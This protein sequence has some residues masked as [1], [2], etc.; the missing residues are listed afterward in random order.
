MNKHAKDPQSEKGQRPMGGSRRCARACLAC[1]TALTLILCAGCAFGKR[2]HAAAHVTQGD[3][4]R[5]GDA[6]KDEPTV[7]LEEIEE[8]YES[9]LDE[10]R[11]MNM[12][13]PLELDPYGGWLNAP[14]S[15]KTSN[16]SGYFRVEKL[17]GAWWFVTPDGNPFVSKGVTDVN[18]LG[19]TLAPDAFHDIIVAKYGTEEAWVEAARNRMLDWGFNTIG[20]WSSPS[21][22]KQMPHAYIILDIGGA[23]GPRYPG[24]VVSDYYA[25]AFV[26]YAAAMTEQ[27]AKPHAEDKN[28]IGFFLDNEIVWGA[29]HF[30]TDKSLL[31]LHVEFP[32]DAPGRAEAL[33]FI[34]E[35]AG[36]LEAFNAAWKT[37]ITDW[38]NLTTLSGDTFSPD[39]DAARALTEAFML[40]TFHRYMAVGLEALRA[41][42][43]HHLI[44]GCRFHN[45]PGDVLYEAAAAYFDVIA[46]AFYEPR[47]PVAEIDAI[48]ERVD[49]P[50][51]IEE[52]TFKSHDSGTKNS[53]F[54]IYAPEVRTMEE[55]SLAYD[56]YIETFVRRPYG[57]GYH[58][59][60][61]MDNP[62]LPDKRYSGDNCGLLNQNDEAYE[63]FVTFIR[64]ANR[65]VER[66]HAS[67]VVPNEMPGEQA[68]EADD[69][70]LSAAAILEAISVQE[71]R[72][73][74]LKEA[75]AEA[76]AQGFDISYPRNDLTVA[77]MF[78]PFGREDIVQGRMERAAEAAG[79]IA[80]LLN[81]AQD[82]M[83][84]NR[85][86]PRLAH[87]PIAIRDGNLWA[88]TISPEG[89]K[90]QPVFL[91]GYGHFARLIE[92]IPLLARMG[93]NFIQFELGPAAALT[94]EGGET[95]LIEEYVVHA[96]DRARDHGVRV[97]LLLSPHQNM[98]WW[99]E[100][101]P[102]AWLDE[103]PY[104]SHVPFIKWSV[105]APQVRAV[106]ERHLRTIIPRI[107]DHPALHSV[108]LTNEPDYRLAP[109]DP[110]RQPKWTEYLREVH[111]NVETLNRNYGTE[112]ASFEEVGHP[113]FGPAWYDDHPLKAPEVD[114]LAWLYDGIRFNQREF[115]AWHIWMRDIIHEIAPDLPVHAKVMPVVWGR[116]ALYWGTDPYDFAQLSQLNGNDCYFEPTPRHAPWKST[117]QV[118]NM[119]YDLQRAMKR[120]PVI[121]TE[122]HIIP[123]RFDQYVSPEHIYTALWQGAV[124]G[125]GASATWTWERTYDR[126]SDVE[127][128]ILH[129]AACTAEMGR[130][131]LDLMR[132]GPEMAA[133]QNIQPRVA[134]LWSN[135]S[136]VREKRLFPLMYRLYEALNFCGVPIGFLSE[137]QVMAEGVGDCACIIAAGARSVH[138]DALEVLRGFQREGGRVVAYGDESLT[139]DQYGLA[140]QPF[141][142]DEAI[143]PDVSGEK[144]RDRLLEAL[145]LAGIS[146]P[147]LIRNPD[148]T[149]NYG[150]EWRDAV[151]DG[152]VLLN[153]VNLTRHEMEV[154]L[155]EGRW[156]DLI[157]GKDSQ[158]PLLLPTNKPHLLRRMGESKN[159]LSGEV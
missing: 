114:N 42:A 29:D 101:W 56:N 147:Y 19:A 68:E 37:D 119:Y 88:E 46:M 77:E 44:L 15:I 87:G 58:W 30:L 122:N 124:H 32:E 111:G 79:E 18:W 94:A 82:E 61:W 69:G 106:V 135:A 36:S 73:P 126:K 156:H 70:A 102:E 141:T 16:P 45:Y 39:T 145:G 98:P 1:M 146:P 21:I 26:E 121:N 72:L 74:E 112:H 59:Y 10:L 54:G 154:L 149:I 130:V 152:G 41:A 3:R 33:R 28:L 31:Q 144:L 7:G 104:I 65:R 138:R 47:P 76:E 64:E 22:T 14:E 63:P 131:A 96:L 60:K 159:A 8:K 9:R 115:A 55:R 92:D 81:R 35:R 140:V 24:A 25:P 50:V 34:R 153:L 57:I 157:T 100:H 11:T 150:V 113:T 52:W 148:G 118:Q 90:E 128:L 105:D 43:P 117:W 125:Q 62:I 93:I 139:R 67:G 84:A 5:L 51:L 75:L 133:V 134:I 97:D 142:P 83:T 66:W 103:W 6:R 40:Q 127:G 78:V 110:W 107:K 116:Y 132:L 27:R 109:Q 2:E 48:Y 17:D 155:P 108:C 91:T 85:V 151:H 23:G 89:Q 143:G 99:H 20:P 120:V 158:S 137:E 49:K 53:L 123:D 86:A 95:G 12:D 4:P 129:R 38:T 136:W 13:D 80:D 71:A